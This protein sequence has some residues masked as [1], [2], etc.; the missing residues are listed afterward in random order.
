MDKDLQQPQELAPVDTHTHNQCSTC[1][2]DDQL[3]FDG[4]RIEFDA[5]CRQVILGFQKTEGSIE[6]VGTHPPYHYVWNKLGNGSYVM[7]GRFRSEL[8]AH[9]VANALRLRQRL[10]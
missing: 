8:E 7:M 6:V 9:A 2:Y 3:T 5:L 1:G 10:P 4:K